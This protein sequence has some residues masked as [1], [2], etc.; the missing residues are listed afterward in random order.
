[1]LFVL[2][3][4]MTFSIAGL[5][6]RVVQTPPYILNLGP[7]AWLGQISY[8]LYLWQQPFCYSP[9][10]SAYFG[11][12]V[13]PCACASYYLIEQPLLRLRERIV[14][15]STVTVTETSTLE[16]D[17]PLSIASSVSP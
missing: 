14:R 6:L 8:S 1:M 16:T 5:L 17:P 2:R 12:L 13:L 3:P 10:H 9:S 15:G 4:V 7:V 11:L